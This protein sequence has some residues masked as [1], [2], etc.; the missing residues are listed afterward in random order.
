MDEVST[1]AGKHDNTY[2]LKQVFSFPTSGCLLFLKTHLAPSA[3]TPRSPVNRKQQW[4]FGWFFC[5]VC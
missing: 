3:V 2:S 4:W 5:L 1:A